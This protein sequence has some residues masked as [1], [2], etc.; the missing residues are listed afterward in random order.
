MSETVVVKLGGSLAASSHLPRLLEQLARTPNLVIAPGG[1]P[2]ADA[3]RRAQ[4]ERGFDDG[5]G[6]IRRPMSSRVT[7][8]VS[9]SQIAA[10]SSSPPG[11]PSSSDSS[12]SPRK[13]SA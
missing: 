1:G 4:K 11:Q 13:R 6:P 8:G 7:E 2:F 9:I 10:E 12:V 5:A 3:V